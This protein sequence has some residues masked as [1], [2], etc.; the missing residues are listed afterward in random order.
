M[1]RSLD[2]PQEADSGRGFWGQLRDPGWGNRVSGLPVSPQRLWG[3]PPLV[4]FWVEFWTGLLG[5]RTLLD[6]RVLVGPGGA[7]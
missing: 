5:F 1:L 3:F 4:S 2:I 6:T 7:L